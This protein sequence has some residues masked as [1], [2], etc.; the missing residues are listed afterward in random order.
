M[1]SIRILLFLALIT[2]VI[3]VQAREEGEEIQWLE[4]AIN[5]VLAGKPLPKDTV[6]VSAEFQKRMQWGQHDE[7]LLEAEGRL[8]LAQG[9]WIEALAILQ[10]LVQPTPAVMELVAQCLDLKGE[11]YESAAWKLR[12][13]R[14]YGPS[15]E[16]S[17]LLLH[18]YAALRP[19]DAD[20][21]AELAVA[22]YRQNHEREAAALYRDH[23]D[24][25]TRSES[26]ALDAGTVLE[27]LI[28]ASAVGF[29]AK[30]LG[31]NPMSEALGKRL[32]KM[33]RTAP[34]S[35][36]TAAQWQ[37]LWELSPAD[38]GAR[39]R[40]L[41]AWEGAGDTVR[42]QTLLEKALMRDSLSP[43]LNF[44]AARFAWS[45]GDRQAARRHAEIAAG[46]GEKGSECAVILAETAE[47]DSAVSRYLPQFLAESRSSSASASVL[48]SAARGLA[49]QGKYAEACRLY[50]RAYAAS[51]AILQGRAEVLKDLE[52]CQE[53]VFQALMVKLGGLESVGP[54]ALTSIG[55][56]DVQEKKWEDLAGV[57]TRLTATVDSSGK[58]GR[59]A[60]EMT[61]A[62][63]QQRADL[64]KPILKKLAEGGSA[65]AAALLGKILLDSGQCA[66]ALPHLNAAKAAGKG[67][68]S[69]L[70]RCLL[71]TGDSAGAQSVLEKLL[72]RKAAGTAD[73]IQL[74]LLLQSHGEA[75]RAGPM[76]DEALREK[77]AAAAPGYGEA[78][79]AA[80]LWAWGSGRADKA[81]RHLQ[82]A[83]KLLPDSVSGWRALG[84]AYAAL[85][86]WTEAA[87]A[88]AQGW[89]RSPD[90]PALIEGLLTVAKK[91]GDK[92]ALEHAYT[93]V[94]R[95]D[96]NQLEA[97]R[98]FADLRSEQ[99][100]WAEASPFLRR[101]AEAEPGNGRAWA[102]YGNCLTELS[103]FSHA[104][105]A[106][107]SALDLGIEDEDVFINRARA[108]REE[109]A[110]D[111]AA[112]I[113]NFLLTRN[114]KSERAR[115]WQAKFAEE[116]G[117]I[118]A[119]AGK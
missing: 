20:A 3:R 25:F 100:R 101:L 91:S 2:S 36:E 47:N 22:L 82:T 48:R 10:N 81:K 18:E 92:T 112:S 11:K 102:R 113:L 105:P 64:A 96:S 62:L 37:M 63:S 119:G 103:D 13:A 60:L 90:D 52:Q 27:E 17:L 108:Y 40:A 104:G 8:A 97:A 23:A 29:Y 43:S 21:L 49:L 30:A 41:A 84:Q 6:T 98:F 50:D 118:G 12:A 94:L 76:L 46:G 39:N 99:K 31:R 87:E 24:E 107:Q 16:K 32:G 5:A 78:S 75:T 115:Q 88:F 114:P 45:F 71:A 19:D 56:H 9:R 57:L 79:L 33:L 54:K 70:S 65:D 7:R 83:L 110:K 86:N 109:G 111:M 34:A 68:E 42:H 38:T 28:P 1:T 93:A 35:R 69:Q 58:S 14:A 4:S 80:G 72:E 67:V 59:D 53:P 44:R 74:G 26:T 61:E 73:K 106:L 89:A 95:L 55:R 117:G 66:E 77:D 116:D 85:G 15:E 51:P